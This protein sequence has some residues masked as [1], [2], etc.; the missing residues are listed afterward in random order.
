MEHALLG[1]ENFFVSHSRLGQHGL[2]AFLG[3]VLALGLN[4]SH[5]LRLFQ[6]KQLIEI[7]G[8]ANLATAI[9]SRNRD[10][11]I[12][13]TL[14]MV[15]VPLAA[16]TRAAGH[17][18]ILGQDVK[19]LVDISFWATSLFHHVPGNVST[20]FPVNLTNQ[21]IADRLPNARGVIRP[22]ASKFRRRKSK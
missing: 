11:V 7:L 22:W 13:H 3:K 4:L 14:G 12:L 16:N 18:D 10:C 8:R 19:R 15:F 5:K 6:V 9:R 21:D 20:G 1:L 2:P 17:V